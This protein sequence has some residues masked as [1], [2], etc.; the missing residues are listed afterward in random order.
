M[1]ANVLQAFRTLLQCCMLQKGKIIV[2]VWMYLRDHSGCAGTILES[3]SRTRYLTSRC[4]FTIGEND[5][6]ARKHTWRDLQPRR[7]DARLCV[8][9]GGC[10]V[11]FPTPAR[12]EEATLSCFRRGKLFLLE[13]L[14]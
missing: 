9:G 13:L 3:F 7:L 2:N 11:L 12:G 5:D 4:A 8:V 1:I 10:S 14:A 6:S